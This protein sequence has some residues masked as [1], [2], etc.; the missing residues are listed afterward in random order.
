MYGEGVSKLGEL[1]DLGLKAGI[2]EKAGSWFSYGT[3]RIGQGR[4]NAKQ[5]LRDNPD[6]AIAI[7]AKVRENAGAVA[8]AMMGSPESGDSS[9]GEE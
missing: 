2:V 1:I 7:E 3:Q 4:E 8:T 9:G 6:T 5:Y